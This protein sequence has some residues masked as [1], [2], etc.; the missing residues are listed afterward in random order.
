VSSHPIPRI[1]VPVVRAPREV[2]GR[3]LPEFSD[4]T[5]PAIA[6]DGPGL[7]VDLTDVTFISSNGLGELV[8][9][10]MNLRERGGRI[11]LAGPNKTIQKL[12]RMVGLD[13]VLPIFRTVAEASAHVA[14]GLP[15]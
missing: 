1:P 3:V 13:S 15:R 6:G 4:A 2:T 8:R 10:G 12:L 11:A 7:V 5:S 14:G 9:I